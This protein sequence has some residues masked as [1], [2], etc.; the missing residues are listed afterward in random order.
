MLIID[1]DIRFAFVGRKAITLNDE[2][3]L[4]FMIMQKSYKKKKMSE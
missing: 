1:V 3:A 4:L 2:N